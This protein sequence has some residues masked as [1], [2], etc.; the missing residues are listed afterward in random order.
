VGEGPLRTED[1]TDRQKH[2]SIRDAYGNKVAEFDGKNVKD[3]MGN[4]IGSLQE[5]QDT[6]EG[7]GGVP[8]VAVW[9]FLIRKYLADQ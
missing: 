2:Q 7:E 9:H 4:K 8:L 3:D 6:V 5:I 1:G